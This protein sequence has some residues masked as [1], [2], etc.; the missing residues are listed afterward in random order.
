MKQR[1]EDI[2]TLE[3]MAMIA[4]SAYDNTGILAQQM[5]KEQ[6]RLNDIASATFETL[7]KNKRPIFVKKLREEGYSQEEIGKMVNRSQSAVSKYETS[8]DK[9]NS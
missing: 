4:Q 6:K 1:K 9:H 8:F 5:L 3:D 7:P 2:K